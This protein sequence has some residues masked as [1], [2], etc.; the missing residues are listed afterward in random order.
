MR[1]CVLV[2]VCVCRER[3]R[4]GKDQVFTETTQTHL[5][6]IN[7]QVLQDGKRFIMSRFLL[8]T[9]LTSNTVTFSVTLRWVAEG[10]M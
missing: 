4:E 3:Q 2:C 8:S 9:T 6:L 10:Q 5:I 1:A 7:R